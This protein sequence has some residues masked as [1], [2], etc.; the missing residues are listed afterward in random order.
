[1]ATYEKIRRIKN[2]ALAVRAGDGLGMAVEGLSFSQIE[3]EYGP[4]GIRGF[5]EE[6]SQVLA[7]RERLPKGHPSDDWQLYK[8]NVLS[9]IH[10][11][12]YDPLKF[13][14]RH[15]LEFKTSTL[16]WGRTTK[17]GWKEIARYFES[18]GKYGRH[19][20][21]PAVFL[22]DGGYGNGVAMQIGPFAA[23]YNLRKGR[24]VPEPLMSTV[25]SLGQMTHD[26]PEALIC[27]FVLASL[28]SFLLD[29]VV[30]LESDFKK[31]RH[32]L[33]EILKLSCLSIGDRL[34]LPPENNIVKQKLE[35]IMNAVKTQEIDEPNWPREEIGTGYNAAE[36][37]LYSIAK[38]F[39]YPYS[40][41][42]AVLE[43]VNDGGDTDSTA[44]MVGTL[45]AANG[46]DVPGWMIN[47]PNQNDSDN[48]EQ[49]NKISEEFC[50]VAQSKS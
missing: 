47:Y 43:A 29:V 13:A 41:E 33:L 42:K 19:Y 18:N 25:L 14:S 26:K 40:L 31:L 1:M 37:V 10:A 50:R 20:L 46:G 9:F 32:M 38:F 36:S 34:G 35:K 30:I 45:I 23:F 17:V 8:S 22:G 4:G 24:F 39:Q 5:V 15:V 48:P 21:V 28:I 44:A 7:N 16:G 2:M 6:S 3:S 12:E 11:G 27:P 49:I